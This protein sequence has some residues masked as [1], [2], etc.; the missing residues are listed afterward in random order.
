MEIVP[1]NVAV[2]TGAGSGIGRAMAQRFAAAKMRVVLADIEEFALESTARQMKE[3]GATVL[4]FLLDVSRSSDVEHLATTAYSEY[5]AVHV[6]CNNAGV[7]GGGAPT[8]EHSLDN[9]Q[10]ILGVNL[11]GVIHGVNAFVPRMLASGEEGHVVNTASAA[12]L[13][14]GPFLATYHASKHAVVALS[15]SLHFDLLL[16]HAKVHASVLCPAFVKTRIAESSRNKPDPAANNPEY[17]EAMRAKVESGM[18]PEEIAEHVFD[19]VSRNQFWILTHADFDGLIRARCEG[20]LKRE[21][22]VPYV[23]S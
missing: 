13:R 5:G 3:S 20:M 2:V 19:A 12:G 11:W 15:E 1:G 21:N 17:P 9:W 8:W 14:T 6:L 7:A 16:A 22:P 10:W 4:P 18:T 23:W